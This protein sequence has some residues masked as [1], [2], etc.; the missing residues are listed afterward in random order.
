MLPPGADDD[1]PPRTVRVTW[2]LTLSSILQG[3]QVVALLCALVYWF[4]VNAQRGSEN[5][6]RLTDLQ[7]SFSQ[8][9]GDVRQTLAVGLN[10]M[11]QQLNSLPDTRARLDQSERRF[12]DLD[13]RHAGFDARITALEHDLIQLRG[14]I[15]AITRASNVPLPGGR[16]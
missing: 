8:Q 16:H 11:R 4:V 14:D 2:E 5:E 7:T 9:M 12:A 6:R 1:T 15:N 13:A 3:V 10:D